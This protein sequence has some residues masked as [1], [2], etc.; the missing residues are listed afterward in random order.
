MAVIDLYIFLN[1]MI[2]ILTNECSILHTAREI[3]EMDKEK[4]GG[5]MVVFLCRNCYA[6]GF[7]IYKQTNRKDRKIII[8]NSAADLNT[9]SARTSTRVFDV[10]NTQ[11]SS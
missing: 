9:L 11:I 10:L 7:G 3:M 5:D 2:N 1:E 4:Y 6:E 8:K